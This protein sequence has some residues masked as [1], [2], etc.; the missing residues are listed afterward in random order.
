MVSKM[1]NVTAVAYVLYVTVDLTF[2]LDV[3]ILLF[4]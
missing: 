2:I 1:E 3:Q 4:S